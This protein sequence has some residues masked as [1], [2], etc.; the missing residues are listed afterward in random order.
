[1]TLN[2]KIDC[3]KVSL[4]GPLSGNS[5]SQSANRYGI[6]Y[7]LFIQQKLSLNLKVMLR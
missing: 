6:I 5:F 4:D 2:H 3:G 1:M 7:L